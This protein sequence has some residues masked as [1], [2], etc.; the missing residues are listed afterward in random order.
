MNKSAIRECESIAFN[1]ITISSILGSIVVMAYFFTINAIPFAYLAHIINVLFCSYLL[2]RYKKT[3]KTYKYHLILMVFLFVYNFIG[4]W[5]VFSYHHPMVVLFLTLIMIGN[6]LLVRKWH[7]R[8]I[9]GLEIV[10]LT[11]FLIYD[12]RFRYHLPY[13]QNISFGRLLGATIIIVTIGYIVYKFKEVIDDKVNTLEAYSFIDPLT[14][15]K[16]SRAF[17]DDYLA[18]MTSWDRDKT[19]FALVN[20]D[21]ND[22]KRINDTYGHQVG[23]DVLIALVDRIKRALRKGEHIYRVGGDEFVVLL[24]GSNRNDANKFLMRIHK[25]HDLRLDFTVSYGVADSFETISNEELKTLAD[26][27]MYA[28]KNAK[29]N[30]L[31]TTASYGGQLSFDMIS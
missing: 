3:R 26:K 18:I 13:N 1:A 12:Y 11:G 25:N 6:V 17:A 16:N 23:D 22:F 5:Y 29:K 20:I 7:L 15:A 28:N 2:Y 24:K 9:V 4:V 27:R 21:I 30:F 14:S 19:P 31:E 8:L 10:V